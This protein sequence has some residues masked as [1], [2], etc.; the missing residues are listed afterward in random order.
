[1]KYSSPFFFVGKKD[2]KSRLVVNYRKL[3][4]IT[5]LDQYP[6]Y[7]IQELVDKVQ[8]AKLFMK[9]DVQKGY[10]NIWVKE[11]DEHKAA[12]KTNMG[13]FEP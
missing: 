9:V 13:L 4:L 8:N 7:L 10:N 3:N 1:M 2:G 11:G 6:L 5:E 12:V